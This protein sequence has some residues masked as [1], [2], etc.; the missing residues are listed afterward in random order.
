MRAWAKNSVAVSAISFWE[1]AVLCDR[2]RIR[3]PV[4]VAEWRKT[5][6]GSG[7]IEWPVDGDVALR[8]NDL[9][10]LPVDPA[11]R[12]IVATALCRHAD[13]MTADTTLLDWRHALSRHD[14][15]T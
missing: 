8:A 5:L 12:F 15:R 1:I 7:L 2:R 13:V 9:A 11:D 10:T 3:L 4:P 14:A 6:L